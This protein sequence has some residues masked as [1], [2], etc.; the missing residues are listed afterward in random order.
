MVVE[1]DVT[2]DSVIITRDSAVI[3]NHTD[4]KS[5]GHKTANIAKRRSRKSSFGGS[6]LAH[7]RWTMQ[8]IEAVPGDFHVRTRF[9]CKTQMR[10][11]DFFNG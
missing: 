11:A 6:N 9:S 1:R 10:R 3:R 7:R 8:L 5:Q 2:R 4:C